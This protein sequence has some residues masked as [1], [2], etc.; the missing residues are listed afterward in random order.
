MDSGFLLLCTVLYSYYT[1]LVQYSTGY[2]LYRTSVLPYPVF[3]SVLEC[4]VYQRSRKDLQFTMTSPG[5]ARGPLPGPPTHHA[6]GPR[7]RAATRLLKTLT[8][9]V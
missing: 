1:P 7:G 8:P 3:Y 6:A 5:H 2:I 4:T 9:T